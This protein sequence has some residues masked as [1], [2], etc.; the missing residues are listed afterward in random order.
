MARPGITYDDVKCAAVKLLSLGLAPSVQRIRDTLGT[1]SNT[2]IAEHL[3]TWR[4]EYAKKDVHHLPANMPKELIGAIEVFWQTAMEQAEKEFLCHKAE[5]DNQQEDIAHEKVSVANSVSTL[6]EQLIDAHQ[7]LAQKQ[8]QYAAQSA[9]LAVTQDRLSKFDTELKSLKSQFEERLKRVTAEKSALAKQQ[10]VLNKDI[11]QLQDQSARIAEK[12]QQALDHERKRQEQSENRWLQLIDKARLT[13]K[14]AD[15]K[16]ELK[17]K[18]KEQAIV[19][20][21]SELEQQGKLSTTQK[22][23][24]LSQQQ[25]M[26]ELKSNVKALETSNSELRSTNL[27]LKS[28][29]KLQPRAKKADSEIA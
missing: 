9:K 12:H 3:R 6:K 19:K 16:L 15:H 13:S 21:K 29:I 23:N 28:E 4:D 8:T 24:I 7:Q 27:K 5:L 25:K 20:L 1:G 22:T 14:D 10:T 18:S 17:I 11:K 26:S 2:T